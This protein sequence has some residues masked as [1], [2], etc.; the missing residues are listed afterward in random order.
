MNLLIKNEE[1]IKK[2]IKKLFRKKTLIK[3]DK[4]LKRTQQTQIETNRFQKKYPLTYQK[5]F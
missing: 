4:E 2:K 3:L 1:N 5:S